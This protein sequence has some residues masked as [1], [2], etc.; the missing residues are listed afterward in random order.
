MGDPK[1][2]KKH[3]NTPSHPFRKARIES[4]TQYKKDYGLKNKTEIWKMDSKV[5][6]FWKQAKII[7]ATRTEQAEK[8]RVQ[9]LTKLVK[10]GLLQPDQEVGAVLNIT[11]DNLLNR[12]LQTVVVRKQL[13]KSMKQSRQFIVHGHIIVGGK[14][15]TTPSYIVKKEEE[16][17][18]T[19]VQSSTLAS[20]EHPER[21]LMKPKTP[22]QAS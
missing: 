4:E 9:L 2:P 16:P 20:D 8:E 7:I 12:R 15:I 21:A 18:I 10:I 5:R 3:Y 6:G 14:I 19:F 13:A 1:K 17:S 22:G 11:L